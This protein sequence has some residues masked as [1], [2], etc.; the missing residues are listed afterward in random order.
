[1]NQIMPTHPTTSSTSTLLNLGIATQ[2]TEPSE[3]DTGNQPYTMKLPTH[4]EQLYVVADT[5]LQV[6]QSHFL[7]ILIQHVVFSLCSTWK[8]PHKFPQYS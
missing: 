3:S 1:M 8:T 5:R 4:G 7:T 2:A 6:Q